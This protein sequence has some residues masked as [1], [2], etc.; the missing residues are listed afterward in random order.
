MVLYTMADGRGSGQSW[1][2][3]CVIDN[4]IARDNNLT[5]NNQYRYFLQQNGDKL[6]TEWRAC[7]AIDSPFC[8]TCTNCGKK[9]PVQ[10]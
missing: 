7:A 8:F 5:D 2:M 4:Q 9:Y 3:P 1:Y 6:I 10:R